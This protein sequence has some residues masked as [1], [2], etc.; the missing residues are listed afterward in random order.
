MLTIYYSRNMLLPLNAITFNR[1]GF[2]AQEMEDNVPIW[3][4]PQGDRLKLHYYP[5]P[6]DIDADLNNIDSVRS[7]YRKL[8]DE[9]GFGLIEV[10]TVIIDDCIAVRKLFKG[11]QEPNGRLY[12]GVLTFPFRDFSF[13]LK[14]QCNEIGVTGIR[15]SIILNN[16]IGT[17]EVD[18]DSGS[19]IGWLDDPYNP[20]EMGPMTRNKSERPEYDTQFP[21][22]PL[23]RARWVLNHLECTVKIKDIIK[24][25]PSFV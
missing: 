7:T 6:P 3:L 16:M 20:N 9:A 22:H 13:V 12:L 11:Q 14:V 2:E 18:I 23:S 5:I 4:T 8:V 24:I 25:Q 17:G 15:D 21:D 10:E 19:M 1:T